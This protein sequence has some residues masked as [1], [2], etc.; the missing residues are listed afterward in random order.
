MRIF[1]MLLGL[2]LAMSAAHAQDSYSLRP[3]DVL[4]VEV[5][6]DPSLNRDTLVLPDGSISLPMAGLL[7]AGG[8]SLD[9]VQ[10]EIT[11]RLAPNFASTPTVFVGI[12]QL[13]QQQIGT[14]GPVAANTIA[15]FLMGEAA[16]PGRIDV[17]PGSTLLQVLAQAG[18]FTP[19]AAKKRIQL[20]RGASVYLFNYSEIEKTGGAGFETVVAKGDVIVIPTRRLF[21]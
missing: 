16:N 10:A 8:R 5:L 12:A 9:A 20:R 21:E 15:V 19:F 3:G 2:V 14:G 1:F 6:E 4:R 13:A 11:Q 7:R 18:G 17:E